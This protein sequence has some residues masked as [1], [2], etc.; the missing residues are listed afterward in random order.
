VK[1]LVWFSF[2]L[3]AAVVTVVVLALPVFHFKEIWS[4]FAGPDALASW[5]RTIHATILW[6]A[7]ILKSLFPWPFV[8]LVIIALFAASKFSAQ[9]EALSH[10]LRRLEVFGAK[11][12]FSEETRPLVFEQFEKVNE[13]IVLYRRQ[14]RGTLQA[15][16]TAEGLYDIFCQDIDEA[17]AMLFGDDIPAYRAT[18]HIEDFIFIAFLQQLFD[19]YPSGGGAG[20]AFSVRYGVIGKAWRSGNPHAAGR[21]L[22]G[23]MA[24]RPAAAKRE[25]ISV[26]WAMTTTEA[27]AALERPS[28]MCLPISHQKRPIGLFY[29]DSIVE[30]AFGAQPD[31]DRFQQAL[32]AQM[33]RSGLTGKLATFIGRHGQSAPRVELELGKV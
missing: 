23:E 16:M 2:I 28:Y 11:I 14:I 1:A 12:E 10:S 7:D 18:M 30:D 29:A 5:W 33:D 22:I 9:I 13:F 17:F 19:Y 27:Q 25:Q 3:A 21:L 4:W 20:R 26:D 6:V 32:Q 24:E 8:F 15:S 31:P